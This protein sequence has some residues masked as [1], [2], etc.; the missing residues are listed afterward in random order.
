M[1][2]VG[3]VV[4]AIVKE[5]KM[6]HFLQLIEADAVA[7]RNEPGCLRF[8]V[9]QAQDDPNKFIFYELYTDD[10]AVAYHNE[11][12]YLK[13]VIAF[14]DEGGAEVV[15]KKATGKFMTD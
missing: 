14:F 11:Q 2:V 9:V 5:D 13:D 10:D 7:S 12:Q 4:E 3:L 6:D 1:P 8:D 15:V